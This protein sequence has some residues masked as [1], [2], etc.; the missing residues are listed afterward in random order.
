MQIERGFEED[1]GTAWW[2]RVPAALAGD[3]HLVSGTHFRQFTPP[4]ALAPGD[5]HPRL[6]SVGTCTHT[7]ANPHTD[8]CIYV[9][10]RI[11]I[12]L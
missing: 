2:L 9:R 12:S 3:L 10:L 5:L 11:K 6:G 8:T 4:I 1:G 7:R